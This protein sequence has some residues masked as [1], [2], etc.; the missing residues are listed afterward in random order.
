MELDLTLIWDQMWESFNLFLARLPAYVLAVM[1][2]GLFFWLAGRLSHWM[3]VLVSG[4][5]RSKNAATVIALITRWGLI[6]LGVLVALSVAL[7]SFRAGD[8]IQVLG[9]SSVAIGF[10][11]RDIFQN[12][13]AGLIILVTDAFQIGDQIVVENEGLEGTVAD[14]QTRATTILTYDDRLIVIP[15]ATLFT[16]AVTINT[17]SEKRRSEQVVGIGYGSDMDAAIR[18]IEEAMSQVDSVLSEPM[19]DVLV[20]DLA[21]SSVNLKARWWTNARRSDVIQ[22]KSAVVYQIKKT[23]DA[24]GIEIPYPIRTLYVK[25]GIQMMTPATNGR[26]SDNQ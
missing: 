20:E 19:P 18:L 10:A 7:P 16:N 26:L 4:R 1:I 24:H 6:L 8:L 11:F 13:L 23:L 5:S 17:A 12:F 21:P 25:D 3:K 15:N 9:I 2:F 22:T 14:I